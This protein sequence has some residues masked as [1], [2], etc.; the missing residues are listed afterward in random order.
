M[1]FIIFDHVLVMH[2]CRGN[3]YSPQKAYGWNWWRKQQNI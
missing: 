2:V 1:I 3:P